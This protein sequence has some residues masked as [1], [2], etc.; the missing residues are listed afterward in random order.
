ME[1][2]RGAAVLAESRGEYPT[3]V[4]GSLERLKGPRDGP[5]LRFLEVGPHP[6]HASRARLAT[7][8]VA[9]DDKR[10]VALHC[11]AALTAGAGGRAFHDSLRVGDAELRTPS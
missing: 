5:L 2:E 9:R 3:V 7:L 8:T 6:E 4:C 1:I 11:N 10:G